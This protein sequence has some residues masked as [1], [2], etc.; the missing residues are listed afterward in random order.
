[1]V[2]A[3]ATV[4]RLT[5]SPASSPLAGGTERRPS[6]ASQQLTALI[7]FVGSSQTPHRIRIDRDSGEVRVIQGEHLARRGCSPPVSPLLFPADRDR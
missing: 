5:T 3:H 6:H 1:M 4:L 7:E 2:V